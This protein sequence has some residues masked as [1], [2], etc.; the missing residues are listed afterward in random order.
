MSSYLDFSVPLVLNSTA[1]SA[2]TTSATYNYTTYW[3]QV[4]YEDDFDN[5]S[6][7]PFIEVRTSTGL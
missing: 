2:T 3:V 5:I 6:S 4:S 7:N 1:L